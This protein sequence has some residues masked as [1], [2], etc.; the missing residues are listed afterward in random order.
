[1]PTLVFR[2]PDIAKNLM[3][4]TGMN[5][6]SWSYNLN[7]ANYPTYGGEVVQILSVYIDDLMIEGDVRTYRKLEEIYEYF[8]EYMVLA[9]QG[10]SGQG[11][12]NQEFMKMTY[13][14]RDWTIIIQPLEAPSFTYSRDTVAPHWAMKA[15]IVDDSSEN[16]QTLKE[17]TEV[18][19]INGEQLTQ[20]GIISMAAADPSANPWSAPGKALFTGK[21]EKFIAA[22]KAETEAH[23][24]ELADYYNKLLPAY[25]QGDYSA[26]AGDIAKPAFGHT[27]QEETQTTSKTV[28]SKT[29]EAEGK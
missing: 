17:M 12:F 4:D 25:L 2:H 11:S 24:K 28:E 18:G 3:V 9:S 22:S 8:A 13:A 26:L 23:G 21:D 29:N 7:V 10:N 16:Y 20:K 27:A 14:E 5:E 6:I 1:M 19:V 15:H